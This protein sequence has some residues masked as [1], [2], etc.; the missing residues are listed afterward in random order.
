MRTLWIAILFL[1]ALQLVGPVGPV[2]AQSPAGLVAAYGMNEGIGSA[3][4]NGSA[5][6]LIGA[7]TGATWT[8]GG[9]FG[10]ALTF[11]GVNDLVTVS[12]ASALDLTTGMT[13]EAWVYPTAN[14]GGSWRNV[15]IKERSGGEV[16]NLYANT[17]TNTPTV[18][19]I[20][21]AQTG[22]PLDARGTSQLPL[23]TWSHLAATFDNSTLRLYVDGVQVGSR[24]GSGPLLTSSGALRIGGN[25]VWGELFQGRI[26]EVRIYNRALTPTEIQ[27]DMNTAIGG[28]DA[29]APVLSGGAPSGDL[30]VGTAQ[31]TVGVA[32]N[33]NAICRYATTAG[34]AYGS[35]PNL[36]GTTGG[37][38]HT[39]TVSG[40]V[41]GGSYTY[42]VRCQDSSTNVNTSDYVISFGVAQVG[43]DTTPPSVVITSP[44][45]SASISGMVSLTASATDNVGVAGVRLLVDNVDVG[46]E[47]VSPPYT[48]VWDTSTASIGPHTLRARARD[49]AGNLSV[50][51]PIAVAVA[52]NPVPSNFADE[53]VIGV[54]LTF[55]TAFEFLPGGR[56][57]VTEFRGRVMVVQPGATVVDPTPVLQLPNIFQEDVTAGGERGLVNIVADPDFAGNGYLYVFYT[58]ASPQRDR[59]SRFTMTGNTAS[60]SSELVVWQAIANST[61]TDH[62]GGGLAFGPDGKLYISTGDNGDPP[63]SQPLSSDHGKILR[64]NKNGTIPADNPFVDGAGSNVD[65]IWIRGLRNPYRF[66]FDTTTGKMYIGDVGQNQTEE[67]NIGTAGANY[68]WPTCEGTCGTS[69]M[70]NPIFTYPHSGRDAAVTGGFVYRGAQFPAAYQGVYFHGDFAQNWIHYLTF[71]ASGGVTSS[72]PFL[73]AD[74]SAD[75]PYD[76]IML[77]P[78]PDGSLYYVDFGWGW[79]GEV[80]PAAIRRI[81]YIAGN[82]PPVVAAAATPQHGLPPLSVTFSSA[83][84]FD[85]EGQALSY[86]WTFGDGSTSSAANPTHL[87]TQSGLYS[88]TLEASDSASTTT[89]NVIRIAVGNAP[90][91]TITSPANGAVFRAGDV[92][93]FGG[94]ATDVEDGP[95]APAAFSW[96][97]LFHHDSHVHPTLG[98]ISGIR[99]GTFTIPSAGHDFSGTTYYEIILTT[100]DSTGLQTSSSVSVFP[101]KVNLTFATSPTGLTF[102]IDGISRTAPF[103]KDTLTGFQHTIGAPDQAQGPAS[104]AFL[105]W[106]DGGPQTHAITAG[107]TAAF[108]TATFQSSTVISGLVAAYSFNENTGTSV[109]DATG[110]GHGGTI[111]G[112]TW[113]TSGKFGNALSFD[114]VNDWVTIADASDLDLTTGMTLE[115]WVF[116]TATSG[117]REIL[118]K[119]GSGVDVYNLYARNGSGRPEV[120]TFIGGSNRVAQGTTTLTASTWTHVA[121]TYDGTTVRLF[122]NGV[123]VATRAAG[124]AISTSTGAL[125]IGGSSLWGEFFRGRLD[126]IRIYNRALSAAEITS[127]MNTG[128]GA[129]APDTAPP[130]RS[131]GQPSGTLPAGTAQTT[132][133]LTTNENATCRFATTA[134]VPYAG[135]PNV[136]TTTGGTSH[137]NLVAGL[138]NGTSYTL[139]VR[140]QD[141]A[142]NANPDDVAIAFAVANPPPPDTTAPVLSM[143]AP[144]DGGAVA[145]SV[146]VT[147]TAT[148]N[149]AVV[150]VQFLLDGAPLGTEDTSAP[151]A[152]AWSSTT[153]ANG[154]PYALSARARD[155]AGNQTTATAVNITV[156]NSAAPGLVASYNFDEGAGTTLTDRTAKGHTGTVSGATWTT[157]GRFGGALTFDGTNDSVAVADAGD[158]DFTTAMTLEAWVYPT[159]NGGG[160]W[161]NVLIKERAGGE[162]YNLYANADTNAPTVFLVRA[163]QSGTALDARGGGQLPLNTWTHLAATFDN[164]TL[165]LYVDGVQVGSRALA[166]PLLTSTGALRFG[167]NS[168]WG[169]FFAG[170]ID[171]VK[172]YNRALSAVEIQT[173]MNLPVEP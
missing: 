75:G 58:A 161:R 137:S 78:G 114:G 35:M 130:V 32:T 52:N 73:P 109:T 134:G 138:A 90:Q 165:R 39:T 141:G 172:I 70:T 77:K 3:V 167:G 127:D 7:I 157:Q 19:A 23:N 64:V 156:N 173:D 62:H 139:Y 59:V 143:T 110:L 1:A 148:D 25:N 104:Y 168:L 10:S 11:D 171:D 132:V 41:D 74:G 123:Q 118:I 93:T 163:A 69:G 86:V 162:V 4:S 89:S 15:L 92:I 13:L 16:Y 142:S 63:S 97:I 95:L 150:G 140:C 30:A 65:A 28:A 55:P 31:T 122:I 22:T 84:S 79:L 43:G 166:G 72:Q 71:N 20:R 2:L 38:S 53:V 17:G 91:H 51:A 98:P 160:S 26:D 33:E 21:A 85:P 115:A 119:E 112:A 101:H 152:V 50:S 61:S 47:V 12:D 117:V 113:T 131:N 170:R 107:E 96:T 136:F 18:Y 83:G 144:A 29:G 76:P 124:G 87:Y 9:K 116:P 68:G 45:D 145:G 88:V 121:G 158:L 99:S 37:L 129:T 6:G 146:T 103:V 164:T 82:Q 154:G 24:A 49:G 42:Y 56:M 5:P 102:T 57:L 147:A 100:T 155:A 128:V 40:L 54:G 105:S 135:L 66:S 151:Y 34:V 120:N 149:V 48:V 81:R 27:T 8:A 108:Y 125:R 169:E 80:N 153:V 94:T 46:T 111:A 159:V 67:V 44:P 133:S 126:E 60:P 36:F 106:S 14:G